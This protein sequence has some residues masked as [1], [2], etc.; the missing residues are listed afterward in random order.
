MAKESPDS[1][2]ETLGS[3]LESVFVNANETAS[4]D[5]EYESPTKREIEPISDELS[6][7]DSGDAIKLPSP[8]SSSPE[9]TDKKND[10]E[11]CKPFSTDRDDSYSSSLSGKNSFT[12]H[13]ASSDLPSS[14]SLNEKDAE[15]LIWPLEVC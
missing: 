5:E 12:W 10:F 11:D 13:S 2:L 4:N 14:L 1:K 9:K 3:K 8:P 6:Q 15:R 7:A